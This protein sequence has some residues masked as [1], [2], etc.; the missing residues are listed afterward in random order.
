MT[1]FDF[2]FAVGVGK[3]RGSSS[4]AGGEKD[5][6]LLCDCDKCGTLS[7]GRARHLATPSPPTCTLLAYYLG[8]PLSPADCAASQVGRAVPGEVCKK[9]AL[10]PLVSKHWPKVLNDLE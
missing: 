2:G 5:S 4:N 8:D 1:L 3:G 9:G 6:G 7:G 10:R